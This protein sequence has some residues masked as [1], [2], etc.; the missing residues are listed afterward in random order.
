MY[1]E[2]RD[3]SALAFKPTGWVS[4]S[5]HVLN[6]LGKQCTNLKQNPTH[7][8]RHADLQ[9]DRAARAAIYPE[10]LCYS[11]LKGLRNEMIDLGIAFEGELGTICEDKDEH[12]FF[13][14][15]QQYDSEF[16]DDVSGKPLDP[17]LV[18]E[19]RAEEIQ[20]AMKHGVWKKVSIDERLNKTGKPPVGTRWVDIN[21]GDESNPV[22]RSRL[23]G[24]EFRGKDVR[25]DLF[26]ATP[27]LE[28]IKSLIS[29]AASQRG[30]KGPIKKLMFI[31]VSKAYFHAP[32]KRDVYVVLPDEALSPEERGGHICGKLCYSLY[33]T[34]DA[35][36]NWEDA[37]SNFLCEL[38]FRRGLSSPCIFTIRIGI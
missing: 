33:G 29:L 9:H 32:V 2:D 20:G 18:S 11:I 27:P 36:Q 37:Y 24:R 8:H 38:G 14:S 6:E 25:D 28:A 4:N 5:D 21:K 16:Y 3:G 31:D 7:Y 1:I 30:T 23:V 22:Y 13:Q 10:Q 26:A 34:R 17:K 12:M 19:A 35:A 15:I